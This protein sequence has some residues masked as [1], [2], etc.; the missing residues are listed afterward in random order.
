[1][2]QPCVCAFLCEHLCTCTIKYDGKREG[3]IFLEGHKFSTTV[4][5]LA[6]ISG[7]DAK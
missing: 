4:A 5:G 7:R 1:M 6:G 2:V 3:H